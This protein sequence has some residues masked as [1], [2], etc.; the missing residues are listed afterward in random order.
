MHDDAT[1]KL[2]VTMQ[3]IALVIAG[4]AIL[5]GLAMSYAVAF[6]GSSGEWAA[7]GIFLASIFNIPAGIISLVIGVTV[8]HGSARLRRM[9]IIA[10][11]IALLLPFQ[12]LDER[13]QLVEPRVPQPAIALQRPFEQLRIATERND[14]RNLHNASDVEK[15]RHDLGHRTATK[16]SVPANRLF[17]PER[18]LV[19]VTIAPTGSILGSH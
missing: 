9:C 1:Y 15:P 7:M 13:V 2:S 5:W 8:K 16:P 3:L 10:S 6:P 12:L 4:V 18:C 11:L 19:C 17:V 14:H